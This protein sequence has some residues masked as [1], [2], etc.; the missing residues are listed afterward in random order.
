MAAKKTGT[1]KAAVNE[2]AEGRGARRRRETRAKLLHAGHQ[3]MARKGIDATTVQEITEAADVAFGS[4]YNHFESKN[5]IVEA[6]MDETIEAFGDVLD[7]LSQSLDDPAE[8][9]AASI[10]Y[11]VMRAMEDDTWGWFLVRSGIWTPV[12]R[13]GL[14]KRLARDIGIAIESGRCASDD[15]EAT[16]LAAAG[17]ALSIL[18]AALRDEMDEHAPERAATVVMRLLGLGQEEATEVARRPLPDLGLLAAS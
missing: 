13:F 15:A 17:T 11:T 1:K 14:V 10:R 6:I 12:F 9:V 5:A 3:V 4:F 18:T 2:A 16:V 7:H 8:V